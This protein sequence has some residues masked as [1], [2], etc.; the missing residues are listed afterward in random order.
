LHFPARVVV[1]SFGAEQK[2]WIEQEVVF[3]IDDA[4]HPGLPGKNQA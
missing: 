2:K 4:K 3:E 1:F